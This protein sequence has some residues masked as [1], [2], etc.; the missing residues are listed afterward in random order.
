MRP[1]LNLPLA[2]RTLEANFMET[3]MPTYSRQPRIPSSV[4]FPTVL[5]LAGFFFG[6]RTIMA[7]T[8]YNTSIFGP[9]VYVLDPSIST[10]NLN[11]Q[12]NALNTEAQFSTNRYAVLFKP[13]TYTLSAE[14]GYYESIAGLGE[15]PGAVVLNGGGVYSDQLVSGNLTQNFWRSVENYTINPPT[16][17][18]SNPVTNTNRWGVSQGASFRRIHVA[19]DLEVTNISCNYASGG[20][21]S[22]SVIDD[23]LE[24]CSQQQW[25]TRNSSVGGATGDVWNYVFSGVQGPLSQTFPTPPYTV[26]GSTPVSREKPFL[27]LDGNGNYNVFVPSLRTNSSGTSWSAT[28]PGPGTSLPISSFF[29]ASPSS[30]VQQINAAIATPGMN[31][32]L[33]PGIYQLSSPINVKNA[34]TIVLGM[35]YAT[36]VPQGGG[37][38]MTIADV[39]GVQIAGLI[40]DAGTT[41]SQV[42]L[43]VGVPGASRVSHASNPTSLNDVF[44][45]IGGAT[46][47]SAVTSIEIDSDN[48]I[49]D[50]IWAWRADHGNSPVGWTINTAAHGLVVN[51]DNVTALGL[52]VEHYQQEQTLWNGNGG[53]TIFYQSELPYDPPSQS[54][55]MDGT[56]NGYPSYSVS[57]SVT[58]HTGYGLGVY[59]FFNQGVYITDDNAIIVP[60]A[61]GVVMR[62]LSTVFLSSQGTG[63]ITHVIDNTGNVSDL[64][65]A[66]VPQTITTYGGVACTTNCP[67]AAPTNLTAN[68]FSGTQVSLNWTD[69]TTSGATYVVYRSTTS[70]FTPSSSTQIATTASGTTTFSDIGLTVG[71]TYYYLIEASNSNG[72]SSPSNQ[73]VVT[74]QSATVP[75]APSNLTPTTVS[76][77]QI[78]LSWTAST[79]SGASYIVYRS[80]TSG[81]AASVS[82]QIGTTASGVTTYSDSSL[83]GNTTYYYLVKATNSAGTSASSNQASATTNATATA[84]PTNLTATAVSSTQINLAW[85]ASTT[86][87]V[88]YEVFGSTVSGFTPSEGT[89]LG[90]VSGTSYSNTGLTA[91]TTYYYAV[92]AIL[93]TTSTT[94]RANATTQSASGGGGGTDVATIDAGSPTA[95]GSY[96]A[97]T[98]CNAGA[99]YDPGQTITIPAAIANTAAPEK[100]YESA[101]QGAVTYTIGGLVSGNSYTVVLHFAELYFPSAGSR[102][103]NVAINGTPVAALQ[104]FDIVAA[105]GARFTAVVEKV[106]NI[107]AA[108]GKI[109]ISFTNGAKDQPMI[110]GIEIQGAPAPPTALSIDAGSSTAVGSYAADTTCSPGAEYDPGQTITIPASI[111][112]TAAPEK[113][114]ES[115]CQG[116]VTYTLTGFANNSVHTVN[117]HFAELYFPSAGSREFNVA[118][119]GTSIAALQNF[120][121]V[122]AAGARFTAVDEAIPNITA[123]GGQIVIS[124]TNGAKDQP[125]I[126]GISV[127]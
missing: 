3:A 25:Y 48:V 81:F 101:C 66:D 17:P 11:A 92:E 99:E 100:V 108:N 12:L 98:T 1:F 116:A 42:L 38:S 73:A 106:P 24:F 111:A 45:R 8:N 57:N 114:Y 76:A 28:D 61:A 109:V 97:D 23:T 77:S 62:D 121:I 72:S 119:N 69:S 83:A 4:V 44:V 32:I 118:I 51:G 74:T 79:T 123:T 63:Q 107:V 29:I 65:N 49:L 31:L 122:A 89:L 58:S 84:P 75:A 43:Q 10:S 50:N 88:Y 54:A 26:L 55:W 19:G 34:N 41:Q 80:M 103:F 27:Y 53:E 94:A 47:G 104:N 40:F 18:G 86:A 82:T 127:Q 95:V 37:A 7:Q 52:A 22:D 110:N 113:V 93:S 2:K 9:N 96:V 91:S 14:V 90:S 85:T 120:D 21:I 78:N 70:G 33:T 5:L 102:E 60:N 35:G 59:S 112:S 125:M 15:T 46:A 71:T 115:A 105:A 87:G 20:F 56:A 67:P 39:D 30:S 68:A 16:D 64:A 117:L 13:G 36:L 6:C 126:N 124:F